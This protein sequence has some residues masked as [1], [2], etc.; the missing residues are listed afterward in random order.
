M[1]EPEKA[2]E[3]TTPRAA[4]MKMPA[5]KGLWSILTDKIKV[6]IHEIDHLNGILFIDHI[7]N[8]KKAFFRLNS[9][10]DLDPIDYEK[11]IK[12]NKDLFPDS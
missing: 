11:E 10:G 2:A 12:N 9:K 7:K 3:R 1:A 6:T 5:A 8:N 4:W